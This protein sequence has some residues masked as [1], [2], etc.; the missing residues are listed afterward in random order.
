MNFIDAPMMASI[1]STKAHPKISRS[2]SQPRISLSTIVCRRLSRSF[3]GRTASQPHRDIPRLRCSW[4][5]YWAAGIECFDLG[6]RLRSSL[7]SPVQDVFSD[8]RAML[9]TASAQP[10]P[11]P[12][13]SEQNWNDN[14]VSCVSRVPIF[15]H[16]RLLFTRVQKSSTDKTCGLTRVSLC[17]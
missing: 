11:W 2:I 5:R 8:D 14:F 7:R 15:T 12:F 10:N 17:R 16:V 4:H 6:Q 9:W 1:A 13:R 3:P